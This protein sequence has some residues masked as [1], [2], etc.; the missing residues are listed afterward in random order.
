M[1]KYKSYENRNVYIYQSIFKYDMK[2]YKLVGNAAVKNASKFVMV[3]IEI[4]IA[5]ILIP[6]VQAIITAGNFT[7]TTGTV[8]AYVPVF[9]ALAVLVLVAVQ[10]MKQ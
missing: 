2:T 7:G 8:L 10:L 6:I 9:L 5:V 3:I 4:V 1:I